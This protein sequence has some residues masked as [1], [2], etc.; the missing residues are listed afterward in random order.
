VFGLGKR[1][2]A[3]RQGVANATEV[4]KDMRR[5]CSLSGVDDVEF[6][7]DPY[8]L[9]F[10]TTSL[11]YMLSQVPNADR[12][13]A[14]DKGEVSL[15]AWEAN[16]FTRHAGGHE[17]PRLIKAQDPDFMRGIDEAANCALL[18]VGQLAPA[19]YDSD[20]QAALANAPK[21]QQS[22]KRSISLNEAASIALGASYISR[23]LGS[24]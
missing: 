15:R 12:L 5:T 18:A 20:V 21:I 14:G 17:V 1:A 4:I 24:R 23:Q 9:G 11:A 19:H 6:Q 3:F 7:N 16:D 10:V 2:A 13:S 22:I 8:I